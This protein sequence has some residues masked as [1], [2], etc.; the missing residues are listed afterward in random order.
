MKIVKGH[1]FIRRCKWYLKK[2]CQ[3]TGL[4]G[5]HYITDSHTLFQSTF[6][7]IVCVFAAAFTVF[8]ISMQW[9]RYK[10]HRITT[11]I[12]SIMY[13]LDKVPF[14][15]VTLCSSNIVFGKYYK[16]FENMLL[17][18]GFSKGQILDYFENLSSLVIYDDLAPHADLKTYGRIIQAL[19]LSG[20]NTENVMK[21]VAQPCDELITN[22]YWKNRKINCSYIFVRSKTQSGFCCTL[23]FSNNTTTGVGQKLGLQFDVDVVEEEYISAIKPYYGLDVTLHQIDVYPETRYLGTPVA[24][25]SDVQLSV[26]PEVVLATDELRDMDIH[27]RECLF[28]E[29]S[30]LKWNYLYTFSG[31]K[32]KCEAEH[33][34]NQCKCTPYY[35]PVE[36]NE[37]VCTLLD[38]KCMRGYF[39]SGSGDESCSCLPP[40][41]KYSYKYT[42]NAREVKT[43]IG[44]DDSIQG[45]RITVYFGDD[46]CV[47]IQRSANLTWDALLASIGGVFGLC[48]GGSVLSIIELIYFFIKSIFCKYQEQKTPKKKNTIEKVW[49]PKL[50]VSDFKIRK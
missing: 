42:V 44:Y 33:L 48:L 20:F 10:T 37:R 43:I 7:S 28:E 34:R 41:I 17:H 23:N 46:Q 36:D 40:C 26:V 18:D 30:T 19:D 14:P 3:S 47:M 50:Y 6:W 32:R 11:S 22:C 8:L 27:I 2:Y 1:V 45:S 39:Y 31:C 29:E 13:P 9:Y 5:F 4:H 12:G 24:M 15:G 38:L 49:S 35:Y 25:G 16:K 21:E